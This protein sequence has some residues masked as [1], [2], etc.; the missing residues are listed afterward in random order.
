MTAGYR[1]VT[2]PGHTLPT[3]VDADGHSILSTWGRTP[4]FATRQIAE[5][6]MAALTGEF[7]VM[8]A[9]DL[10][11]RHINRQIELD[12]QLWTLRALTFVDGGE[13]PAIAMLLETADGHI[14]PLTVPMDEPCTV[15]DQH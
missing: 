7:P 15:K 13:E 5:Q 11:A 2:G 1:L 12:G 14:T 4:V 6:V 10:A 8:T 3:I 9:G